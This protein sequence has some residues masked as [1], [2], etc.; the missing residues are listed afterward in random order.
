MYG[1]YNTQSIKYDISIRD[2]KLVQANI[3]P[4]KGALLEIPNSQCENALI[5]SSIQLATKLTLFSKSIN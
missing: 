5:C 3:I 4:I 2:K 1:T